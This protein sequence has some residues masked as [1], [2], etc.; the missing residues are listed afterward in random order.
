MN[1]IRPVI[2][3]IVRPIIRSVIES[4]SD[5]SWS[6]LDIASCLLLF[7]PTDLSTMFTDTGATTPVTTVDQSIAAWRD[8]KSSI[9][10]TQSTAGNRPLLG[11]EPVGGIRNIL[12][13][14]EDFANAAWVKAGCNF[15]YD[16]AANP[17]NAEV[18]ADKFRPNPVNDT[19]TAIQTRAKV[20]TAIQYTYSVYA[21]ADGE[22]VVHLQ[23]DGGSDAN[24]GLC[25]FDLSAG[26]AGTPT[27]E[28]TFT[29]ASSSIVSLGSGWYRCILTVTSGT[30]T[31]LRIVNWIR[32]TTAFVGDNVQGLILWGAQLERGSSATAY[33]KVVSVTDITESGVASKWVAGF[34]G[35]T[36]KRVAGTVN[37]AAYDTLTICLG[38][39]QNENNTAVSNQYFFNLNSTTAPG[40]AVLVTTGRLLNWN[41]GATTIRTSVG[42]SVDPNERVVATSFHKTPATSQV[43]GYK[44]NIAGTDVSLTQGTGNFG[45]NTMAIGCRS[46]G[47]STMNGSIY[48][49][50]VFSGILT[51]DDLART[52]QWIADKAGVTL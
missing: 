46:P 33:Q 29:S 10:L 40:F 39:R 5:A 22:T 3:P 21:K 23:I 14:S 8:K 26:T 17:L 38:F 36:T 31:S 49:I 51:G 37:L 25:S 28:G 18:T 43:L 50:A 1:L 2:R 41:S 27:V 12:I 47:D 11:R 52:K 6:P 34:D 9:L 48:G 32:Q 30:E 20:A 13:R 35:A 15:N 42:A 45:N 7:D 19:K 4:G 16:F 44:N 24:R